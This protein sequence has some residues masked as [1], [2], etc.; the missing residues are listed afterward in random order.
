M[1]SFLRMRKFFGQL[2][3]IL[4]FYLLVLIFFWYPLVCFGAVLQFFGNW[5]DIPTFYDIKDADKVYELVSELR[6]A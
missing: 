3:R 6:N 4:Q 2:N 1:A 5:V